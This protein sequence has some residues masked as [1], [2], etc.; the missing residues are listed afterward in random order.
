MNIATGFCKQI[1]LFFVLY[2]RPIACNAPF[3]VHLPWRQQLTVKYLSQAPHPRQS[4]FSYRPEWAIS[5]QNSL[6]R[7]LKLLASPRVRHSELCAGRGKNS[8]FQGSKP[9]NPP[10][11]YL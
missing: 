2:W 10:V 6:Q 11:I 5:T 1:L 4:L 7:P 8:G 3:V 9:K